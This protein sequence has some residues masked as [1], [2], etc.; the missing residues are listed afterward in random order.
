MKKL[1]VIQIGICHE[2]AA[3]TLETL[4]SLKD[5]FEV[6]G[7]VDDR[8][9]GAAEPF[10]VGLMEAHDA[11][12]AFGL[13]ERDELTERE[14]KEVVGGD[15]EEVIIDME[16]IHCKEQVADGTQ[17]GVVGLGAIVN[18]GDGFPSGRTARHSRHAGRSRHSRNAGR[19]RH[20][21]ALGTP[22]LE[23]GGELVVGD[24]DVFIYLGDGIDVI[25][26]AIEY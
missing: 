1:R 15:D 4:R 7:L 3:G 20:S 19:R 16:L 5:D 21:E 13:G 25:E 2:L 9:S 12:G 22:L 14:I 10:L 17:A 18:D 24:D 8:D 23:D 26:H 11:A 6:V